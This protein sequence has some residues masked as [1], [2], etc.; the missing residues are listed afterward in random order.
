MTEKTSEE[1]AFRV[2]RQHFPGSPPIRAR[3]S[4]RV[5]RPSL[6]D[7]LLLLVERA[8]L[9]VCLA[10]AGYLAGACFLAAKGGGL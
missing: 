4:G 2:V 3:R 1:I 7:E 8:A 9:R 10:L 6:R 5:R